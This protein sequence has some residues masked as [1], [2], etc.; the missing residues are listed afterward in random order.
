VSKGIKTK[1]TKSELLL[2]PQDL[3]ELFA[4]GR[5]TAGGIEVHL[6]EMDEEDIGDLEEIR[7][8]LNTEI[9]ELEELEDESESESESESEDEDENENDENEIDSEDEN[10]SEEEPAKEA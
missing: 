4:K 7:D 1:G 9:K 6:S 5:T 2:T 3:H 10:E 8:M